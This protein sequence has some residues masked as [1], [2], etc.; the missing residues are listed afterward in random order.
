M[1]DP[2]LRHYLHEAVYFSSARELVD[3]TAPVLREGLAQ[4][5]E[6]ALVCAERHNRA[7]A[8]ALDGSDR[9]T[10]L[11][12]PTIYQKAVTAVDFYRQFMQERLEAGSAGVRLVGEVDFGSH[13]RGRHE[14]RRFEALCNHAMR[15]YPL[16]S[17][18][19][20]D[21]RELSEQAR[22][23]GALTHPYLRGAAGRTANPAYVDPAK[24]LR[25]ADAHLSLPDPDN[26]PAMRTDV[27]DYA[28]L[29]RDV[30]ELLAREGWQR[31]RIQDVVMAVH[32][33]A[34]NGHRH[35]KPP[36]TVRVWPTPDW[37]LCTVTDRG[38]GFDDPFTGYVRG[39]GET[40][41]EGRFGLWLA[42]QLSDELVASRTPEGFTVRLVLYGG[43]K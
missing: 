33:V 41:P 13:S 11:P 1:T 17:L 19:A 37:V 9:V 29:H 18:C 38:R 26:P 6:V 30:E 5:Q 8:E 36:V 20:Y 14:W 28:E 4:G 7:L 34:T 23:T 12:R 32:E 3:L 42:R 35:G 43:V 22:I 15:P 21:S 39:A 2:A 24:V 40:L 31:D 10:V 16:W 27:S 25:G